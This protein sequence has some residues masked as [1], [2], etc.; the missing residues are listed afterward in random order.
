M[1]EIYTRRVATARLALGGMALLPTWARTAS[2]EAATPLAVRPAIEL[3]TD[4]TSGL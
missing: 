1:S 3:A 4:W 2:V